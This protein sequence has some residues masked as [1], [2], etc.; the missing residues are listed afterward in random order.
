[1]ENQY[2]LGTDWNLYENLKALQSGQQNIH[3]CAS[4]IRLL[5][6]HKTEAEKQER[7]RD[8]E[9]NQ[10]SQQSKLERGE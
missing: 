6:K 7:L 10:E 3:K 2:E 4:N 9:A 8:F 1:M 5:F